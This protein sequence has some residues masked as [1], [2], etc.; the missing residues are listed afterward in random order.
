MAA[1]RNSRVRAL[2]PLRSEVL[3]S[4]TFSNPNAYAKPVTDVEKRHVNEAG[5][6]M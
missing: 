5:P 3:C 6:R 1:L 2:K 4:Q